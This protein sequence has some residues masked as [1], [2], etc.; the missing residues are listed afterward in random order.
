MQQHEW[1]PKA[2]L[3]EEAKHKRLHTVWFH[4]Y[5][6]LEKSS[7]KLYKQKIDQGAV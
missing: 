4:F 1:D 5:D 7:R 6:I 3:T 2:L